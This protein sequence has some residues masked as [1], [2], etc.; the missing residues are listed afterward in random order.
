M[1][2]PTTSNRG[3]PTGRRVPEGY[4]AFISI[5]GHL[6]IGFWEVEVDPPGPDQGEP[7]DITTQH[8][9]SVKQKWPRALTEWGD[10]SNK[11]AFDPDV[12]TEIIAIQ[13]RVL[14]Y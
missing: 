13:G 9:V 4:Q 6:T 12:I 14:A 8:N 5:A 10:S 11:A 7:I 1:A 3:V 2:A